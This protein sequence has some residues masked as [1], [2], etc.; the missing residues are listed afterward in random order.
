MPSRLRLIL[1]TSG[2]ALAV[3]AVAVQESVSLAFRVPRLNPIEYDAVRT[4]FST[5]AGL[6]LAFQ[7]SRTSFLLAAQVHTPTA[8]PEVVWSIKNLSAQAEPPFQHPPT[9]PR[10]GWPTF[11]EPDGTLR[12][13]P[14]SGRAPDYA[15]CR[16]M[17]EHLFGIRL[18]GADVRPGAVWASKVR[19]L[20][21]GT[22]EAWDGSAQ[23]KR[24]AE[25]NEFL[26]IR[27][28][29]VKIEQSG[30]RRIAHIEVKLRGN[31][32]LKL[33]TVRTR[34]NSEG[35]RIPVGTP[36]TRYELHDHQIEGTI[37]LDLND[38]FPD[39]LEIR[40]THQVSEQGGPLGTR[41]T[42]YS[43]NRRNTL[44]NAPTSIPR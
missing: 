19:V 40:E 23:T 29:L 7:S 15:F 17:R 25:E 32:K 5:A 9:L 33:E 2:A 20:E 36:E 22:E 41:H 12:A 30:G 13:Q 26:P 11:H 16:P 6:Q 24:I 4:E 38:G 35:N 39:S 28:R 3:V 10:A 44:N 1:L 31:S 21:V 42:A 34:V 37:R 18:P 43:L 14:L 27:Y 8:G